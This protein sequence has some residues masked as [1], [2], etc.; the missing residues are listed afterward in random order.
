MF[1]FNKFEPLVVGVSGGPDSMALL[2]MLVK[3]QANV[4]VVHI[5]YHKRA[6]SDIDEALVTKYCEDRQIACFVFDGSYLP[7]GNFQQQARDFRYSKFKQVLLEVQSKSLYL[8]HHQ[9]DQIETALFQLLSKR[10]P[11]ILGMEKKTTWNKVVIY[12][13]L[14]DKTKE[15]L[16]D[17]CQ[18]HKVPYVLDVSN[19]LPIY[20]R[21]IIRQ[22]VKKFTKQQRQLVLDYIKVYAWRNLLIKRKISA[23]FKHT[24][25]R[26]EIDLY[27]QF[28][29]NV[30]LPLLRSFLIENEIDVYQMSKGYL[31]ELDKMILDDKNHTIEL[32]PIV[33]LVIE[34]N[35]VTI[36]PNQNPD[37]RYKIES[38]QYFSTPYFKT[39]HIGPNKCGMTLSETDF[40]VVIR[41]PKSTDKIQMR[42]GTKKV[43][44]FFIDRKI[45]RE[46]RRMWPVV[47]NAVGTVIYVYGLGCDVNHYSEKHNFFLIKY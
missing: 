38:I 20:T 34:Y 13:P 2:D 8:A 14:L 16:L 19:D 37:Y 31:R 18:I 5:N 10:E 12:R 6:E 39:M 46:S 23:Y 33:R 35:Q 1:K 24:K 27:A 30:R 45:P 41:N 15:E 40:P 9:D 3:A 42:F 11:D 26:L 29:E 7:A 17:Y 4:I 21:N 22:E 36:W 28:D 47:E 43:S 44:R 25:N 32:S